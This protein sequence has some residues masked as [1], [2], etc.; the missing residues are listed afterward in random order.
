MLNIQWINFCIC[1]EWDP[2]FTFF[3]REKLQI[4]APFMEYTLLC[5]LIWLATAIMYQA[6][7][8][9]LSIPEFSVLFHWS[10]CQHPYQHDGGGSLVTKSYLTLCNPMDCGPLDSSPGDF[11]NKNTGVGCHFFLWGNLPKLWILHCRQTLRL[12]KQHYTL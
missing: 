8:S 11:A 7:F 2:T 12:S 9:I 1:Y 10:L 4:L 3:H 5:P 6:Y